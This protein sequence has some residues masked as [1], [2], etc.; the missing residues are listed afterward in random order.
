MFYSMI[1][2]LSTVIEWNYFDQNV[3]KNYS[4]KTIL[5]QKVQ[6]DINSKCRKLEDLSHSAERRKAIFCYS[7]PT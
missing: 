6:P 5:A 1:V 4:G 2:T 3:S 7:G